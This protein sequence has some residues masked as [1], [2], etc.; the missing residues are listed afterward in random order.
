MT[1]RSCKAFGHI[2]DFD[3]AHH[4]SAP[5]S[6]KCVPDDDAVATVNAPTLPAIALAYGRIPTRA[7][8]HATSPASS[9]LGSS[10]WSDSTMCNKCARKVCR[11]VALS[12]SSPSSTE[13]PSLTSVISG[14]L[15]PSNLL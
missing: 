8:V 14:A 9:S 4:C 3:H 6:I 7:V 5:D 2:D 1:K 13:P 10:A 11:S 15:S 12:A